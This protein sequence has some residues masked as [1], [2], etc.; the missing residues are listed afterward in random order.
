MKL[1]RRRFVRGA[2]A[3]VLGA[4]GMHELIERM[5]GRTAAAPRAPEQHVL[6]GAEI[7]VDHGVEWIVP[8]LHHRILTARVRTE[9]TRPALRDARDELERVLAALD[10]DYPASPR[11]L[12]LTV[13]WGLPYFRRFVPGQARRAVPVDLRATAACGRTLRVLEDAERFPSDPDDTMLEANDV[14]V[15]L[16]S[17]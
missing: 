3:T 9:Q 17:D 7:L 2:A 6:E 11:G 1:D 5:T 16:R 13:G 10:D 15:L 14:A 8:P 4:A 12:T